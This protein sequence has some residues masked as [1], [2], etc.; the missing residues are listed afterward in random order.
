MS[1]PDLKGSCAEGVSEAAFLGRSNVGK[2]SL[3][4][5]LVGQKNLAKSSSTPGKT[6]LI[7]FFEVTY[8][9]DGVRSS[10]RFV[11]LPG[12]GYA[13]V[14]KDKKELWSENLNRFIR[15]RLGIRLFIHL[16]DA[17]HTDLD[18]DRGVDEYVR[19]FLRPD[20]KLLRI[21]TKCDKLTQND[22]ARLRQSNP[23]ALLVSTLKRKGIQESVQ[24][25]YDLMFGK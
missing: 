6:Q 8:D 18:I 2:S 23:N 21:Y 14:S 25:I 11:D 4:N 12:F 9:E 19:G 15:E 20:Q 1:S 3:L 16:V 22:L 10:A 13:K 7:N 5:A 24:K 17:R